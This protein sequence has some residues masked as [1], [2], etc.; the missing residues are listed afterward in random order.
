M[1]QKS[2]PATRSTVEHSARYYSS[3]S[4]SPPCNPNKFN[5]LHDNDESLG[6]S[7]PQNRSTSSLSPSRNDSLGKKDFEYDTFRQSL[8]V[9]SP[10]STTSVVTAKSSGS[11]V[12]KGRI[13]S[14]PVR[15]WVVH[16]SA[17]S[18]RSDLHSDHQFDISEHS[19]P[20][21]C[22]PGDEIVENS[23][24]SIVGDINQLD[25]EVGD[26]VRVNG[27]KIGTLRYVGKTHFS[28]GM[29]AG[30]ELDGP[31]GRNNGSVAGK[32]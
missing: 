19:L 5:N 18:C 6:R 9:S 23:K 15:R 28:E 24:S 16:G 31:W 29:W 26:K 25:V 30:V 20:S 17:H 4:L 2:L 21:S 27:D 22:R 1:R 13:L 7:L 12:S 32:R 10:Q 11:T 3:E 8:F 14:H